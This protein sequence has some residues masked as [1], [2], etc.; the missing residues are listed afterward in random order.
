[1]EGSCDGVTVST[2]GVDAV[3][4]EAIEELE[5]AW[6]RTKNRKRK[7]LEKKKKNK[8]GFGNHRKVSLIPYQKLRFGKKNDLFFC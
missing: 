8:L 6:Q 1:M 4:V 7:N 3:V 5:R 2:I